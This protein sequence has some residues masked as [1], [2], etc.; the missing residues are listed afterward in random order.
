M[1]KARP[2]HTWGPRANSGGGIDVPRLGQRQRCRS[3]RSRTRRRAG[4]P[5][6]CEHEA[7][8]R[9]KLPEADPLGGSGLPVAST[10]PAEKRRTPSAAPR[11]SPFTQAKYR[12]DSGIRSRAYSTSAEGTAPRP[13]GCATPAAL[14]PH[15]RYQH[16]PRD[17]SG[18]GPERLHGEHQ[19]NEASSVPVI[20]GSSPPAWRSS[21]RCSPSFS[22]SR[23]AQPRGHLERGARP[24]RGAAPGAGRGSGRDGVSGAG[25][26]ALAK[27]WHLS[28]TQTGLINS[29]TL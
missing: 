16:Q 4:G 14:G 10:L 18:H 26:R 9:Q 13:A 27:Q 28:A 6:Q 2:D 19:T 17:V 5:E 3:T 11:P 15:H 29:M 8:V 21:A 1:Q 20:G 25:R 12:G 24:Q 23:P 22:P 7:A